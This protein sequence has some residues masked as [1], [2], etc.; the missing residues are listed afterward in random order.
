M[1]LYLLIF[2]QELLSH[3]TESICKMSKELGCTNVL[4]H[5]KIKWFLFLYICDDTLRDVETVSLDL[6]VFSSERFRKLKQ[7]VSEKEQ[8][9]PKGVAL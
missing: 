2:V 5:K 6:A 9:L 1:H 7:V 4:T 3:T 8:K